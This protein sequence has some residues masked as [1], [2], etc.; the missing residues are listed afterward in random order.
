MWSHVGSLYC[1]RNLS[2]DGNE[3]VDVSRES[4]LSFVAELQAAD[5]GY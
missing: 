1:V 3:T 5:R 2:I 4:R